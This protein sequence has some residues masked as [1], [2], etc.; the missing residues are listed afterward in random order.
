MTA[1]RAPRFVWALWALVCV[2]PRV[3]AQG[4]WIQVGPEGGTVTSVAI[5]PLTPSTV[6]AGANGGVLRST[7]GGTSWTLHTAGLPPYAFV[8]VLAID[9]LTPTTVYAGADD[10]V[11]RSLDGGTTWWT[12]SSLPRPTDVAALAI[13]P[14]TPTVLYAGTWE[15]GV[16]RSTDAGA[17]WTVRNVGLPSEPLVLALAIDPAAPSTLYAGIWEGGVFRSTDSGATWTVRSTGLPDASSVVAL[18][19]DPVTPATLYAGTDE[20]VYRSTDAGASWTARSAGLPG[21]A[22][23]LRLAIDPVT[24]ATLYASVLVGSMVGVFRS[25]NAGA[26]WT[27]I[28]AGL[29]ESPL[30]LGL[31]VDP[32]TPATL[33]AATLETGVFRSTNAG[34]SWTAANAGIALLDITAVAVNPLT[35]T[36]LYAGGPGVF[37]SLDGGASWAASNVGLPDDPRI[38]A[39]AVDPVTPTT[40]YAALWGNGVFHSTNGGTSWTARS[41]GLPAEADVVALAIDPMTPAILYAGIGGAGV[42]RTTDGGASWTARNAGLPDAP[43]ALTLAIDP[44]TPTTLYVGTYDGVYRSTDG[45]AVWTPRSAGLPDG[46]PALALA[47]DPVTPTTLYAVTYDVV[48]WSTDGGAI[49]APRSAGLPGAAFLQALAID[50]LTP[51]TLYLGSDERV[52]RST[53]AGATWTA[54]DAGLPAYPLVQTLAIDPLTSGVVYAGTFG[55]SVF[56]LGVLDSDSD[57]FPNGWEDRYGLSAYG[58][59]LEGGPAGDPDGDGTTNLDEYRNGTHPRGF[60]TRYFAEGATLN[61]LDTRLALV[62][63]SETQPANVLLRFQKGDG[64]VTSHYLAV[65]P[66]SRSTVDVDA[67]AGMTSAEF[68]TVVESDEALV[69]D[70]TMTW[71]ASGYG[72][73]AETSLAAAATVWYLAEGATHSGFN[74]FY[75]IQNPNAQVAHVDVTYL[76]PEGKGPI[77]RSYAVGPKS[78]FNVWVNWEGPALASTDVSAVFNS[79]LP[80]IV[81]RAMYLNQAGPDGRFD[82]KDDVVFNAGHESAG[83]TTLATEWFLAEGN[84]GSFFDL[85]VLVANPGDTQ[86]DVTATFL[87]PT[88]LPVVKQYAIAPKS[89]FNIWVDYEDPR[90]ADTPVSTVITSTNGVPVI[91]ERAMWWP[92]PTS[93]TWAEAHNSAGLTETGRTW[94]LAEGE[95]GGSRGVE[96]YILI[97]NRGEVDTARVTLLYEDGTTAAKDVP[98]PGHSRTNVAT[99]SDFPGAVGRRFGA[100]IEALGP[101]PQIVVERAMYSN[102]AGVWWAAGTNAVA[103]KIE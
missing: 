47:I 57:G 55:R 4:E 82:T 11:Y 59:A 30:V 81:E 6:Y 62:N 66:H 95:A 16:L 9:P 101:S 60:F 38:A 2:A 92:G 52:Y 71:D 20:G 97:A 34:S 45:G 31:A 63:L 40:L 103:T 48:Y 35:P 96:T 28:Q 8:Q 15:S 88:G 100:I 18:T 19:V 39:L 37:R 84:T 98:L 7:T 99:A 91:V 10:G 41:N 27:A 25:T 42:F 53:S 79:D 77:V 5:D 56:R 64:S 69:A 29:P 61:V 12:T 68:S 3:A 93:A 78:R 54:S 21:S 51:T 49:W 46:M 89:R 36:T 83:V 75:L 70:R 86:A 87:L 74:L 23:A 22:Y 14:A 65:G 33:F 85:F 32:G 17:N 44:A 58:A 73:H 43:S 26:S 94:V 50:P 80:I 1:S 13:D 72:S 76:L 102:A 24:P 90:L 67:V